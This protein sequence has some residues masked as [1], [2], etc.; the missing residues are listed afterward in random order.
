MVIL[1]L[2]SDNEGMPSHGNKDRFTWD[3]FIDTS[4]DNAIVGPWFYALIHSY[5]PMCNHRKTIVT[6]YVTQSSPRHPLCAPKHSPSSPHL[7]HITLSHCT[8]RLVKL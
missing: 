6:Q 2:A 7:S 3:L 1:S 8:D 5:I 4:E